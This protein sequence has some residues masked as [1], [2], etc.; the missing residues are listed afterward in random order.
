MIRIVIERADQPATVRVFPQD[1]VTVGRASGVDWCLPFQDVSREHCR[2]SREGGRFFIEG[3]SERSPIYINGRRA[4]GLTTITPEDRIRF[5]LCSARL[6]AGGEER[7]DIAADGEVDREAAPAAVEPA[8]AVRGGRGEVREARAPVERPPEAAIDAPGE[9]ATQAP[10]G[11]GAP[12][13]MSEIVH[14]A[15]RWRE[16]DRP[17]THLLRG[18]PLRRGEVWLA[19]AGGGALGADGALVR[20]YIETSAGMRRMRRQQRGIG[21]ALIAGA[22]LGGVATAKVLASEV[23]FDAQALLGPGTRGCQ[24]GEMARARSRLKGAE[25]AKEERVA[26]MLSL[27]AMRLAEGSRCPEAAEVE[28]ALRDRLAGWGEQVLGVHREGGA[29]VAAISPDQRWAATAHADGELLVW[30][31]AEGL[32]PRKEMGMKARSLAWS[33]D[34]RYLIVGGADGAGTLLGVER[35]EI[36]RVGALRSHLGAISTIAVSRSG[37]LIATGDPRGRVLLS[38]IAAGGAPGGEVDVYELGSGAPVHQLFFD[39]SGQRVFGRVGDR[40]EI[41]TL[42]KG[43]RLGSPKRLN[44]DLKVTTIDVSR[45]GDS[46]L[47]GAAS[48]QVYLWSG[49]GSSYQPRMIHDGTVGIKHVAFVP[50]REAA[51]IATT[52][53]KLLIVDYRAPVRGK[54]EYGKHVFQETADEIERLIVDG[55]GGRALAVQRGGSELFDLKTLRRA[56]LV[57]LGAGA[58]RWAAV[59]SAVGHSRVVS[60]SEDGRVA[61]WDI[62]ADE[63]SGGAFVMNDH[64]DEVNAVALASDGAT[65]VSG[66]R[67][68]VVRVTTVNEG[69]LSPR[70]AC[71]IGAPIDRIALGG[72]RIAV[73]A[74]QRVFVCNGAA[75]RPTPQELEGSMEVI[76]AIEFSRGGDWLV[77]VDRGGSISGWESKST[78]MAT[79]A[80]LREEV[81]GSVTDLAVSRGHFAVSTAGE[82]TGSV[83]VWPLS[84]GTRRRE[85]KRDQEG[86]GDQWTQVALHVGG[87][88]VAAGASEGSV[89][90]WKLGEDG[91][92]AKKMKLAAAVSSLEFSPDEGQI[93]VGAGDVYGNVALLEVGSEKEQK[94]KPTQT[95]NNEVRIAFASPD[96]LVAVIGH[97]VFRYDLGGSGAPVRLRGHTWPISS[98][99]TDGRGNYV[100]TAS[101]D[102]SVRVWPLREPGVRRLVCRRYE[103]GL[104]KEE[105]AQLL[106]QEPWVELCGSQ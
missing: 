1:S 20:Q 46:L 74:Q 13:D 65:L 73:A 44:S 17:R 67:D 59:G 102:H 90:V 50:T 60:G 103:G 16:L 71:E 21:A 77:A 80:S 63:G 79:K 81:R 48:G 54:S 69:S 100:V 91:S 10:A 62:R 53:K 36:R 93:K 35:G 104:S 4:H 96:S 86:A 97:E 92:A 19:A 78:S 11:G 14:K 38:T 5:G 15:L 29:V 76:V 84:S 37:D 66:G 95:E 31:V 8:P 9:V 99:A 105:W 41:W 3:L 40:V 56:P 23:I 39:S 51:L 47:V 45:E 68:G 26:M 85:E 42:G 61:L 70:S 28:A 55:F 88:Y 87:Q 75:E 72:E 64:R 2:F 27:Y 94:L 106:P 30:S 25:Q 12:G 101:Y 32:E 49:K 24:E 18:E 33:H 6:G 22:L 7:R 83:V 57:R 89:R 43:G 82:E 52:T 98:F 58:G 34:S